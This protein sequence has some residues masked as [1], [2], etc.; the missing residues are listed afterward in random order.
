MGK[1][2]EEKLN[3]G[4]IFIPKPPKLSIGIDPSVQ[5]RSL[6]STF[7]LGIVKY[8]DSIEETPVL[9]SISVVCIASL[10]G[11]LDDVS[12]LGRKEKAW[13][14]SLASL[15]LIISQIGSEEIN[16]IIYKKKNL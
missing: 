14:I 4:P 2:E 6:G 10:I 7:I 9:V 16:F 3:E 15:P 1:L 12:V 8:F 11:L 13:F 5:G